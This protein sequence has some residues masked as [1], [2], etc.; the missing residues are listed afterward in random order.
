MAKSRKF[1]ENPENFQDSLSFDSLDSLKHGETSNSIYNG[2]ILNSIY[3]LVPYKDSSDYLFS[4]KPTQDL[5]SFSPNDSENILPFIDKDEEPAKNKV[6]KLFTIT[7]ISKKGRKT[8]EKGTNL[9]RKRKN[10]SKSD[11]DN[12]ITKIQVHFL[13]FLIDFANDVVKSILP[14]NNLTFKPISYSCK[15]RVSFEYFKQLKEVK[16]NQL[17]QEEISGKY[18]LKKLINQEILMKLIPQSNLLEDFFNMKYLKL[19]SIYYNKLKP[20]KKV[21]FKNKV[22]HLSSHTKSFYYLLKKNKE[23]KDIMISTAKDA[24]F[25]GQDNYTNKFVVTKID[26]DIQEN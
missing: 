10:H 7:Y 9:K 5:D 26:E 17:L 1:I 2:L 22:I 25:N 18:K 4:K 8:N 16:I 12:I 19:F 21:S 3:F 24:Y 15:K 11:F 23:I 13:N 20:L 14:N 6:P